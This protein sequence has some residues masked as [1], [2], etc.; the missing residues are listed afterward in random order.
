MTQN[1]QTT[2]NE[3]KRN[4]RHEMLLTLEEVIISAKKN[5]K[6][7]GTF[8]MVHRVDRL[9]DAIKILETQKFGIRKIAIINTKKGKD[10][11]FFLMQASKYKK[12]DLKIKS[13]EVESL[14]TYKGIFKEDSR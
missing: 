13:Y 12:S 14:K 1:S 9:L 10:A 8:Y 11:E 5:L 4:A 7:N 3:I 2:E 6:E